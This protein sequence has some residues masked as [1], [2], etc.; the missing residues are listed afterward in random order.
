MR[1]VYII[2]IIAVLGFFGGIF[3]YNKLR[4]TPTTTYVNN[5]SVVSKYS[6]ENAENSIVVTKPQPGEPVSSP[7]AIEGS[8]KGSWFFE[9]SFPIQIIDETGAVIGYGL[10]KPKGDWM[11]NDFVAFESS[12]IFSVP[13]NVSRGFLILKKDNPS[14]LREH[15]ASIEIPIVFK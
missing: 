6:G 4:T 11:T 9:A 15:D 3:A 14:D 5:T 8:V 10:A 12:V 7:I 1:T 13:K 2:V